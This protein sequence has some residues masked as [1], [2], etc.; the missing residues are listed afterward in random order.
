MVV[1][2]NFK[3]GRYLTIKISKRCWDLEL[4]GRDWL[5]LLSL[6]SE[7]LCCKRVGASSGK[8]GRKF[9]R[10]LFHGFCLGFSVINKIVIQGGAATR[11]NPNGDPRKKSSKPEKHSWGVG[12]I[13]L[14]AKIYMSKFQKDEE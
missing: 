10:L 7:R 9:I 4:W 2:G 12:G 11:K 8:W 13:V 3:S 14:S 1:R 5:Y 6:E